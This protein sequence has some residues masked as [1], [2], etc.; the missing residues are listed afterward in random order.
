MIVILHYRPRLLST[1]EQLLQ[2]S[3][4]QLLAPVMDLI[5]TAQNHVYLSQDVVHS[6][7]HLLLSL[8]NGF[9]SGKDVDKEWKGMH[10]DTD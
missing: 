6:A 4:S 3:L 10:F 7:L 8:V 2:E 5:A 9:M 1:S